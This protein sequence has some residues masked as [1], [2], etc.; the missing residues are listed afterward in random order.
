[1]AW[2]AP[3][4]YPNQCWVIVNWT[5]R[6]KLQWNINRN[7]DIFIQ[8]NVF[9]SVVCE[10]AAILSRPQ[11]V[12]TLLHGIFCIMILFACGFYSYLHTFNIDENEDVNQT[13]FWTGLDKIS[14]SYNP[15]V[16]HHYDN[17]TWTSCNLNSPVIRLF[18]KQF[19]WTPNQRNIKV[20][21]T[22]PLWGEFTGDR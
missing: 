9:E 21:L 13:P 20:R 1:M 7:S 4:H 5:L 18:V 12:Y 16:R 2:P 22:G 8:E 6:N 11:C 10:T 17:V 3:S 14:V 15:G 19:M